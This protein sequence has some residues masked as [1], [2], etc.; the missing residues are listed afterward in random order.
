M[1]KF[2]ALSALLLMVSCATTKPSDAI[3]V[4]AFSR[5]VISGMKSNRDASTQPSIIHSD[6]MVNYYIYIEQTEQMEVKRLWIL[7]SSYKATLQKVVLPLTS[8]SGGPGKYKLVETLIPFTPN[9]VF[10]I[11]P[12]EE[13]PGKMPR[14]KKKLAANHDVLV[15]IQSGGKNLIGGNKNFTKLTPIVLQ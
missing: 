3:K 13:T 11:I 12:S 1:F 10:R 5:P 14:N 9:A 4:F 15:E 8:E 2:C 6:G 7:G